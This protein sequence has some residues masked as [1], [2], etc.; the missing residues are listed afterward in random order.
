MNLHRGS[1]LGRLGVGTVA[2]AL[3]ALTVSAVNAG[4]VSP[5]HVG[6]M[7]PRAADPSQPTMTATNGTN[8]IAFTDGRVLTLNVTATD[9][10]WSFNGSRLAFVDSAGAIR[11]VR[12][13]DQGDVGLYV[14]ADGSPRSDLSW[15]TPSALMWSAHVTDPVTHVA[16]DVIQYASVNGGPFGTVSLPSGTNWTHISTGGSEF[17]VQA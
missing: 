7:S 9:G 13:N 14:K 10:A 3:V 8:K 12:F 4:T 5:P 17:Y 2:A 11:T 16:S 1:L 15:D 6:A